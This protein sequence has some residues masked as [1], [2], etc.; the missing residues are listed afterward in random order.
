MSSLNYGFLLNLEL[1]NAVIVFSLGGDKEG[2]I[3]FVKD[4]TKEGSGIPE[5]LKEQLP[6]LNEDRFYGQCSQFEDPEVFLVWLKEFDP[7][8]PG[9]L[10]CM[11]HELFHLTIHLLDSRG[12]KLDPDNH[13]PFAYLNGYLHQVVN[14]AVNTALKEK[15]DAL[16]EKEPSISGVKLVD[17]KCDNFKLG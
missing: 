5:M 2:I 16:I 15:E 9:D 4:N 12:A 13:E 14:E 8:V 3:D 10:G 11:A 17:L 1:Y 6:D 7:S